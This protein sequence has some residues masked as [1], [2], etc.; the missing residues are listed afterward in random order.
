MNKPGPIYL[1]VFAAPLKTRSYQNQ[2]IDLC[3]QMYSFDLSFM[4]E[5]VGSQGR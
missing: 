2:N 4:T 3:K 5:W 1:S